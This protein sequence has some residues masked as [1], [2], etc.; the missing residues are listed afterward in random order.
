[1]IEFLLSPDQLYKIKIVD[2]NDATC[3]MMRTDGKTLGHIGQP[4]FN[5]IF[6][7]KASQFYE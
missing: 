2:E 1:M 7:K 4:L 6:A 3:S 5:S